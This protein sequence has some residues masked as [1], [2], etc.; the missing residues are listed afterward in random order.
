MSRFR[1]HILAMLLACAAFAPF[2][3]ACGVGKS[4]NATCEQYRDDAIEL[5]LDGLAVPDLAKE[6]LE[7]E[8]DKHRAVLVKVHGERLIKECEAKREGS[9]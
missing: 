7:A 5:R 1:S 8:L 3:A 9:R 2:S 6:K 4:A